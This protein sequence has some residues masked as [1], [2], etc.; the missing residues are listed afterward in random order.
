MIPFPALNL[1]I[2]DISNA[3]FVADLDPFDVD[4]CRLTVT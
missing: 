3:A 4:G 1:L 2:D